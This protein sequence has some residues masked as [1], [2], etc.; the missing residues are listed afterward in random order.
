MLARWLSA[1]VGIPLF[2]AL[3]VGP[4]A[5]W[6]WAVL[7]G[8]AVA[9]WEVAGTLRRSGRPVSP[10]VAALGLAGPSLP[11]AGHLDGEP[12]ALAAAALWALA[13]LVGEVARAERTGDMRAAER[14][15]NGLLCAGYVGLFLF[16]SHLRDGVE[17]MR[18]G[19]L[20]AMDQGAALLLTVALAVWATDS[21]ALF[22]GRAFG[23]R[24]LAPRLSPNKTVE[25]G[26]GGLVGAVAVGAGAGHLL[27][28]SVGSGLAIGAIAG[29]LGQMGDLWKSAIKREAGVKDFGAIIPGHGGV[30]DR[31]D[32]LL[33]VA[34]AIVALEW[35]G[36]GLTPGG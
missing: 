15:G 23:R 20:P 8:A 6:Q 19:L 10:A 24:K 11:L 21:L 13:A 36:V 27:L 18:A 17:P 7:L 30:L 5:G 35:L 29:V 14:V 4:R 22:C 31:F 16:V 26:L 1:L 34:T 2:V 28:A 33:F 9:L 12:V 25:G 32:S 3:C